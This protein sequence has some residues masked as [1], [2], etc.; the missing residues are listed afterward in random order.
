[1]TN[2]KERDYKIF[3]IGNWSWKWRDD[4]WKN[5]MGKSD[6]RF[7]HVRSEWIQDRLRKR[8]FRASIKQ[9]LCLTTGERRESY[10]SVLGE[11]LSRVY[12]KGGWR[13]RKDSTKGKKCSSPPPCRKES[14][15]KVEKKREREWEKKGG[16]SWTTLARA[17]NW[18][19]VGTRC[20]GH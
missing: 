12:H 4:K 20:H 10:Y 11:W 2:P 19:I 13:S 16:G 14:R 9:R 8:T 15:P 6:A 17:E 1:M 5:T 3:E 18:K 7:F